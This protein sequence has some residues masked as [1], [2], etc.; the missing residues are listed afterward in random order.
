MLTAEKKGIITSVEVFTAEVNGVFNSKTR[1]GFPQFK[2]DLINCSVGEK[3]RT[4]YTMTDPSNAV[5]VISV[6]KVPSMMKGEDGKKQY[7]V[8]DTTGEQVFNYNIGVNPNAVL[9]AQAN[10][11]A[12]A[13][14]KYGVV[15]KA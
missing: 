14:Q 15:V 9:K 4:I 6:E 5:G 7:I 10:A 13:Y 3:N 8:T 11:T 1:N 2:V 12:E